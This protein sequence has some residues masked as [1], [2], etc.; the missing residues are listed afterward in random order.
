MVKNNSRIGKVFD[1][2]GSSVQ[3]GIDPNTLIPSKD[4]STLDPLRVQNTIRYAMDKPIIVDRNGVVL[5]VHHR[6]FA[7]IKSGRAVDIQIGY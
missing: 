7:A 2:K 3:E 1:R 4:L 5:D 6:L